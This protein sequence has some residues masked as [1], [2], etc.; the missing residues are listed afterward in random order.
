[1]KANMNGISKKKLEVIIE[2]QNKIGIQFEKP[3]LLVTAFTHSS[4]V[5]D[6]PK[7]GLVDYE[8][9]EFLGDAVLQITIS[10]FLYDKYPDLPEGELSKRR[11][12]VVCEES[13][14]SISNDLHFNEVMILGRGEEKFGGRNKASI[15]A[16]MFEALLGAIYL[17]KGMDVVE[18]FLARFMFGKINGGD[19]S[20]VMDYKTALQEFVQKDHIGELSYEIVLEEGPSHDKDFEAHV[21][22]DGVV[23]GKGFG[24]SKKNAQKMAAQNALEKLKK[25]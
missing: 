18:D 4:Y 3:E 9:L 5:N 15:L 25:K 7:K 10:K 11:A 1:M 17:E 23:I 16:D 12:M 2:F 8:R 14:A 22:L 13:L 21:F 6:H 24:K 20:H 19:F